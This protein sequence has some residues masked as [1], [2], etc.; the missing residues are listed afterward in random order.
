MRG[1][2][3]KTLFAVGG[4]CVVLFMPALVLAA[5]LSLSPSSGSFSVGDVFDINILLNTSS[6]AVDGIDLNTLNYNAALLEVQDA[7]TSQAGVQITAGSLLPVNVVN[8]AD[9]ANGRISFSQLGSGGGT[10]NGS[11][12]LATVRFRAKAVGTAN[13]NFSFVLGNTADTNVA[14]AG[15]DLLTSVTNGSYIIA[16]AAPPPDTTSPT[17]SITAPSSG[18]TVSGSSVTV[19]ANASDNVGVVGVQFKLDGSN[20]GTEDTSSPYGIS[21]DANTAANGSHALTAVARDAAGNNQTSASVNITV[22]N[23]VPDLTVPSVSVT[24]PASG[25]SVSGSAVAVS[26][27]ASDNVG[28]VGVQFKLNSS[29]L[30]AEDTVAPYAVSW[31]T[32]AVANG[33]YTLTAAARD[34]AGN[35]ATSAGIAVTVTN[36]ITAPLISAIAASNITSS[37]AAINWTTGETSDSQVEYGTTVAYGSETALNTNLVT[38]HSQ[39][40]SG[41]S[42]LTT[43]HYRVKSRDAAGNLASSP[44]QTFITLAI[45]DTAPPV[46]SAVAA[47]G[48][49][50]SGVTITWTTNEPADSQAEYGTT[51][52]L[53]SSSS[54]D[55]SLIANHSVTLS[56]LSGGTI[57]NYRV[58]SKDA[59]ANLVTSGLQTFSTLVPPSTDSTPPS[60]V[61]NLS[62]GGVTQTSAIVSWTA[63]GDDGGVGTAA[64]YD[65]RFS[66]AVINDSSW[67]SAAQ[68]AGEP[69]PALAGTSQNFTLSGL[70]AG[71][72]YWSALKTQD[73]A[74]NVS[75][76]SNVIQ[77]NTLTPASPT[78]TPVPTP[79]PSPA[80]A[81]PSG[82]GGGG[83]GGGGSTGSTFLISNIAVSDVTA[84]G[85]TISWTTNRPADG[86]V[87]YGITVAYELGTVSATT[88]VTS[89]RFVISNL[90]PK[91]Q[92]FFRV[93]SKNAASNETATSYVQ[94]S[95]TLAQ[96]ATGTPSSN[97]AAAVP[98]S[99]AGGP[100]KSFVFTSD[101][102]P[103]ETG[104]SVKKL[105]E[106]LA[107]DPT[108]YP[109][110][111]ITGYYGAL[112]A[113]AVRRFQIKWGITP[114][115]I[116]GPLTRA[117]INEIY[118]GRGGGGTANPQPTPAPTPVLAPQ[119]P[120]KLTPAELQTLIDNLRRRIL[121]LQIQLLKLQIEELLAARR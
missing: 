102:N 47:I 34:A 14:S 29:N 71:T 66:A 75:A 43:Y 98:V 100:A 70:N 68:A 35:S 59:S 60:A 109:E 55:T 24:A 73:E 93:Q 32:T 8:S 63:P 44:D 53:G 42:A 110:G 96:S 108:L 84:T 92:Y 10:F 95:T 64:S 86:R 20:L 116:V 78:P 119:L 103:S 6:A 115:G 48:I 67:S 61:T 56:G 58:K 15:T 83:G 40:L 121:E 74:G 36:D 57:Y 105:Q 26:A 21:W 37:G 51:P 118:G 106:L 2:S 9:A 18:A 88:S 72:T 33:S 81:P 13:V 46:I 120:A 62:A 5:T 16:N 17:V 107:E 90:N 25:A 19:S 104:A 76:L 85:T 28:I 89:H 49:T 99:A 30:G 23:L 79:S 31:N 65:V 114:T 4:A 77:F 27:N 39:A 117:K 1:L 111:R 41:L 12:T 7:N 101:I 50:A 3:L 45:P 112:T 94:Q 54:L 97:S 11:G 80:P 69:T 91:T 82:G 52:S 38:F 22:S 113:A 87:N